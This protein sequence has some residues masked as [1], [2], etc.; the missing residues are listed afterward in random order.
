MAVPEDALKLWKQM[1]EQGSTDICIV[2]EKMK[3]SKTTGEG[4]AALMKEG[5]KVG[6]NNKQCEKICKDPASRKEALEKI[7]PE[8][9]KKLCG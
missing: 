3:A 9:V 5:C 2:Y 7:G 4:A 6:S 8:Y 1:C